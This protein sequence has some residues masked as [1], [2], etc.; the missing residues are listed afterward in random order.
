M[1][2]QAHYADPGHT[3]MPEAIRVGDAIYVKGMCGWADDMTIPADMES[4][5]R[6][7]YARISRALAAF[8]ANL[9]HVVEQTV[10]VTDIE[11]AMAVAGKVRQDVYGQALP[12]GATVEVSRLGVA[13]LMVEIKVSAR[14]GA[15]T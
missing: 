14:L 8:G 6:N 12:V 4:Q 10:F 13:G 2:R 11:A 3:G 5:M 7:T 9:S 1:E 15:Q